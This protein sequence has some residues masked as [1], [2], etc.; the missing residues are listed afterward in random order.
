[1]WPAY[2]LLFLVWMV[3]SMVGLTITTIYLSSCGVTSSWV[4]W[5]SSWSTCDPDTWRRLDYNTRFKWYLGIIKNVKV[6]WSIDAFLLIDLAIDRG[7]HD[8][9]WACN[10]FTIPVTHYLQWRAD[11]TPYKDKLKRGHLYFYDSHEWTLCV[12]AKPVM[13]VSSFFYG[14][15]V[16]GTGIAS[17]VALV[18][19]VLAWLHKHLVQLVR[20]RRREAACRE[21]VHFGGGRRPRTR[22]SSKRSSRK[23]ASPRKSPRRRSPRRTGS[24]AS[25]A[26]ATPSPR[27]GQFGH[28]SRF[29]DLHPKGKSRDAKLAERRRRDAALREKRRQERSKRPGPSNDPISEREYCALANC[30]ANR[31]HT[32][33]YW[34]DCFEIAWETW[35]EAQSRKALYGHYAAIPQEERLKPGP[36]RRLSPEQEDIVANHA[37]NTDP[38]GSQHIWARESEEVFGFIV[39]QSQISEILTTRREQRGLA[40]VVKGKTYTQHR[41]VPSPSML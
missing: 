34:L 20:R 11:S 37:L 23:S 5:V 36:E 19:L 40:P 28:A 14:V 15:F 25:A 3:R 39:S 32:M 8:T 33:Q 6:Y 26:K 12:Y 2:R 16:L 10:K 38:H 29:D 21:E 9:T 30:I 4:A 13:L 41:H 22:R 27:R 31:G 35:R 18:L 7:E 17:G 24:A 1:M